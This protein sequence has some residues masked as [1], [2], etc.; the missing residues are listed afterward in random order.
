MKDTQFHSS[1]WTLLS[2]GTSALTRPDKRV[3]NEEESVAR[4]QQRRSTIA[5]PFVSTGLM[6]ADIEFKKDKN[7][8]GILENFREEFGE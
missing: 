7:G 1:P 8:R 2:I 6:A 4:T 5:N 3:S